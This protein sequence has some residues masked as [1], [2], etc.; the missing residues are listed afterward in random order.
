MSDYATATLA[1]ADDTHIA[2]VFADGDITENGTKASWHLHSCPKL[3]LPKTTRSSEWYYASIPVAAALFASEQ[4]WD[5]VRHF[6]AQN[7]PVYV[8]M[9]DYAASGGYL[10]PAAPTAYTQC[11][12]PSPAP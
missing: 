7:K 9:G 8:S 6:K 5:A 12:K 3:A 2:V 11:R 1:T 10:S 4:I